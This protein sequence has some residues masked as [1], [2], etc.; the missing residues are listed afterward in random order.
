MKKN[1]I[2]ALIVL[3]CVSLPIAT[4]LSLKQVAAG[5]MRLSSK[6][7]QGQ[8]VSAV[9]GA[10]AN[11]GR[12]VSLD[13]PKPRLGFGNDDRQPI[14]SSAY[15]WSA[16]GRVEIDGGGHCTGALVGEDLVLTNAHCVV[17]D[18]GQAVG[19]TFKP[20]YKLGAASD[21]ARAT[22]TWYGTATPNQER[23][24]DWAVFRLD[25]P[26]GKLY[27]YFGF[28]SL[29]YEKLKAMPVNYAGYSTFKDE[30][31]P[32]FVGGQT[33]QAHM[34]CKIR[35][36]YPE[37]GMLHTD[38]DNGRGGSGGPIFVMEDGLPIIVAINAAEFRGN[39]DYSFWVQEAYRPG[40]GNVAVPARAFGKT[41]QDLRKATP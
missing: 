21:S 38:C 2:A 40:Q 10:S 30:Q 33:A 13:L 15:P 37:S 12:P 3:G 32:A 19:L 20:N 17:D 8:D 25:R 5:E 23:R 36:V 35:D 22:Y 27:G 31:F 26:L 39:V 29:D 1:W 41:I 7:P 6:K 34:G 24:S 11:G 9:A 16:I 28:R 18:R 14:T 4:L